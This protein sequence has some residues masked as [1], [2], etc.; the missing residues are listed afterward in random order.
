[1]KRRRFIYVLYISVRFGSV[2]ATPGTELNNFSFGSLFHFDFDF[3]FGSVSRF[4]DLS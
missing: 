4:S 2:L 1:M 3:L